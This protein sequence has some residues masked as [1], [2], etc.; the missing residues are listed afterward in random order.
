MAGAGSDPDRATI[1]ELIV[2]CLAR[3]CRPGD[4]LVIGVAT[5]LAAAAAHLAR[6]LLVPD[7]VLLAAT[8]VDPPSGDQALPMVQPEW[9][10]ERSVGM[11]TQPE[12]LDAIARG[13]ITLQF[14]SPAQVDGS[15][16]IN[17]S[18]VRR[19]DGSLRRLP[20]SL[21]IADTAGLLGR[22]VVYRAD[23]SPRFLAEQV[24]FLTGAPGRVEAVVTSRAVFERDGAGGF[25]LASV[26]P[27]ETV[28]SV[29]ADCGFRAGVPSSGVGVTE[30]PPAE[31]LRL[32]RTEIDPHGVR[33]LETRDGREQALAA[34]ADLSR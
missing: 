10:A 19:P 34:L 4:V 2:W 9:L 3:R 12:I 28:E 31:A 23:H 13:R 21:A 20:G 22:L 7:I 24:D 30:S 8:A 17:A 14:I 25:A 29:L 27:G 18:R 16:A 11:L 5:P 15:G 6:A 33:R 1:D 32:L 26:H